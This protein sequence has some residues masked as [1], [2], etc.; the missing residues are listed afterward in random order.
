MIIKKIKEIVKLFFSI[1]FL[2][3]LFSGS[4]SAVLNFFSALLF[5]MFFDKIV[6]YYSISIAFGFTLGTISSFIL[7]KYFTFKAFEE[8][9]YIQLLKFIFSA[10]LGILIATII[11]SILNMTLRRLNNDINKK[12]VETISHIITIGVMTIYNFLF[13]KLFAFKKIEFRKEVI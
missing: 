11:A 2:K 10:L 8:K 9:S 5:R 7:N 1:Q 4:I 3:F 13:M 6:Y 12:I